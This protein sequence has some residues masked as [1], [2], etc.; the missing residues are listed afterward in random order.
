MIPGI[1]NL[2]RRPRYKVIKRKT[3]TSA[4]INGNC[5]YALVYNKGEVV[6]AREDSLGIFTF[7]SKLSAESW[8]FSLAAYKDTAETFQYTDEIERYAYSLWK[9]IKVIPIGKGKE[10]HLVANDVDAETLH[11]FYE[12][13]E[14]VNFPPPSTICYKA[15][16][17]V[18]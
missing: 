1:V 8:I 10:I 17:V 6:K 12:L 2:N 15:V 16:Y 14:Q 4:L 9:I 3:R 13:K 18:E 5:N 7:K 11:A